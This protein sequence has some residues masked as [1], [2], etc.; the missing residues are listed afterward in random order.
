MNVF[1]RKALQEKFIELFHKKESYEYMSMYLGVSS[2][3]LTEWAKQMKLKR[4]HLKRSMCLDGAGGRKLCA[5][6]T[7]ERFAQSR[8]LC[9]RH[10]NAARLNGSLPEKKDVISDYL[11]QMPDRFVVDEP[12]SS[13]KIFFCDHSTNRCDCINPG[14]SY[15]DLVRKS[16]QKA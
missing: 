5:T 3:T 2:R 11:A 14:K 10:Y 13:Q 6:Y 15:A 1:K 4:P 8:G 9:M 12:F 7:C 16:S